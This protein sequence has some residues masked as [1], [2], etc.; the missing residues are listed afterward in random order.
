MD[1]LSIR[2]QIALIKKEI[3][4]VENRRNTLVAL[5]DHYEDLLRQLG[6]VIDI[7]LVP[8]PRSAIPKGE[9]SF[10][11]AVI[12]ALR[13]EPNEDLTTHHIWHRTKQLGAITGAKDPERVIDA[14]CYS[15]KKE[16]YPI[17]KVGPMTWQWLDE[18][19]NEAVSEVISLS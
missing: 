17:E 5:L 2:Q 1:D 13:N 16:N 10:R 3:A 15:L 12:L 18:S 4:A 14:L 19:H 9:I 8:L 11:Q 6:L 7:P